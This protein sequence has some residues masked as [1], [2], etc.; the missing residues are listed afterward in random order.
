M[1]TAKKLFAVVLILVALC[2]VAY[3]IVSD[4]L[5]QSLQEEVIT[6]Y[7]GNINA[8]TDDEK[9]KE[10]AAAREYNSRLFANASVSREEYFSL[11]DTGAAMGVLEIP[12]IS[13]KLPIYHGTGEEVLQRGVGHIYGTSLPVGGDSTHAVLSGHSGM[14]GQRMLTDLESVDIGDMFY[15]YVLGEKKAYKVSE[16]NTVLPEDIS[17]IGIEKGIDAVTVVTCTPYGLN[18]HRL[19]VKGLRV[20][21]EEAEQFFGAEQIKKAPSMYYKQYI[22]GLG[23]GVAAVA[24]VC[25]TVKVAKRR[26]DRQ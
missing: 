6:T 21:L 10:L 4:R 11:L 20:P 19:L 2:C 15:I 16:I 17:D 7:D 18:T 25:I 3:P 14:N 13:V 24:V 9:A 22:Y 12:C 26:K 5:Q 23:I 8:M 1:N